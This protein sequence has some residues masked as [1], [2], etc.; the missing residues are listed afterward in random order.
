M[1]SISVGQTVTA[2][3]TAESI[4][5][6]HL[7]N[8][9]S[10]TSSLSDANLNNNTAAA[11]TV[12][13]DPAIVVSAPLVT[14]STT[15]TNQTVATFTH[16]NGVEPAGSFVARINWGDG[17]T[18]AGVVSLSGTTY[19]VTG[20]HTFAQSGSHTIITTVVEVPTGP[21]LQVAN[22]APSVN[23][24]TMELL[25][26]GSVMV[27]TTTSAVYKLTP[28]STGSYANG[29]WSQLASMSTARVQNTTNVLPD[30]RV[31]VI[32][33]QNTNTGEIYDPVAN[34]WSSIA[35]LPESTLYN[36]PSILLANGTVL[37]GSRVG[38]QTYIYNPTTNAWTVGP[39]PALW[40]SE[41]WRKMDQTPRWQHP[42][43][44]YLEQRGRGPATRSYD[45][46]LDRFRNGARY[47]WESR[48][49]QPALRCCFRTAAF[50]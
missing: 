43:L 11:T 32:G 4:D 40:R 28:D 17:A 7:T 45:D 38:P 24:D 42:V 15:L 3:V 30:G 33:G 1:G 20:S 5:S 31:L 18:S 12:V 2:T 29:T 27:F 44:R 9:A 26:D 46:D 10:V 6:G 48:A 23:L 49:R 35:S 39:N 21:W 16:A 22:L 36:V 25:S 50:S 13:T 37:V 8:A 14:S 34:T 19:S 41:L 47:A